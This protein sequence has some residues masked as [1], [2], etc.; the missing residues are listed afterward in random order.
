MF[1]EGVRIMYEGKIEKYITKKKKR[2]NIKSLF[3]WYL[4]IVI[5]FLPILVDML[6]YLSKHKNFSNK[7]WLS[8]CLKG[9]VLWILATIIVL[10]LIDYYGN[11][12]K[13]GQ[14]KSVCAICGIVTWGVVFAIWTVFKYI[15]D[16][17]YEGNIPVVVTAIVAVVTLSFCSPLQIKKEEVRE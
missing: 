9:D 14:F 16:T 10:T 6:V 17:K 13:R 3:L 4:G 1:L 11:E 12:E 15:Y 5:S 7:Y 8:I 2:I